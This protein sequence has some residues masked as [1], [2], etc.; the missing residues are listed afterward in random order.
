MPYFD[1]NPLG[2]LALQ[3]GETEM[4]L[5]LRGLPADEAMQRVEALLQEQA[6]PARVLI[7]FDPATGDGRETLFLPLGRRLLAARKAGQLHSCLPTASADG[8]VI[9]RQ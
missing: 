5:D 6:P 4:E 2:K 9:V 8:Y 1:E 3:S 7:R